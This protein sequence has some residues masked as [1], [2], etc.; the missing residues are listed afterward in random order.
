CMS[1]AD[2]LTPAGLITMILVIP[3]LLLGTSFLL[4]SVTGN[5]VTQYGSEITSGE[6]M[7]V[8][9]N[10]SYEQAPYA[11]FWYIQKPQRNLKL[12]LQDITK[13]ENL[14]DEF[15]GRVFANPSSDKKEFSL[16][17]INA[18]LSDHATY[19]CAMS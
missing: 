4:Y 5:P 18:R 19:F 13:S 15:K 7:D 16:H 6:G 8:I 1:E 2:R 10:C 12:L 17:L 11:M 14:E 3:N 9:L